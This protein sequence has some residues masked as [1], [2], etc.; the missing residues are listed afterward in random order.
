MNVY[1]NRIIE[2]IYGNYDRYTFEQK[3][4]KLGKEIYK[5]YGYNGLF[6]VMN[7]VEQELLDGEYSN[8]YLDLLRLLEFSFNG[9][10]D[11]WQA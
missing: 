4:N 9:I 3:G 10:C 11:E 1:T 2:M 7:L 6:T 5:V 8:E